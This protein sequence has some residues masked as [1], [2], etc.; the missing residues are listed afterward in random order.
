MRHR[1]KRNKFRK[2]EGRRDKF[3]IRER[4]KR[5]K[6]SMRQRESDM[7]AIGEAET[8]FDCDSLM[9]KLRETAPGLTGSCRRLRETGTN[10]GVCMAEPES[11]GPEE[12]LLT[13]AEDEL[14]G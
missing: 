10:L 12:S 14:V 6:F 5:Q 4:E 2:T 3:K 9:W 8:E 11:V 13:M 7:R 1:K